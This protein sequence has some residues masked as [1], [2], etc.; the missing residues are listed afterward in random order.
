MNEFDRDNLNFIMSSSPE[1]LEAFYN[2]LDTDDL[3]YLL[4][5]VKYEIGKLRLEELE[6]MDQVDDLSDAQNVLGQFRL[7]NK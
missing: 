3:T 7:S 6:L 1:E 5:L 4:G 2:T